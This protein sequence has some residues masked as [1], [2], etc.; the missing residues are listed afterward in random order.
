MRHVQNHRLYPRLF[1]QKRP[2]FDPGEFTL[3]RHKQSR[4]ELEVILEGFR[5]NCSVFGA[6]WRTYQ[7]TPC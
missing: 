5:K 2:I 7:N 3:N 4:K 6:I 1:A